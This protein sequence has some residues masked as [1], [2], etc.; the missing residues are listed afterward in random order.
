M[1]MKRYYIYFITV[2]LSFT[3]TSCMEEL[4]YLPG[5]EDAE[6]CYGV[7]FPVQN[8]TGDLQLE[9]GDRTTLTYSV[10]RTNTEGELHVPV[11]I[12]DTAQVFSATEIVFRDE[13]AVAQVQVY[14]PSIELGKTY[15]CTLQIDGDEYVSKYS[16]NSASLRFS[17]TMIKWNNLVGAN[18]ET[19]GKYRDGVFQDW[20]SV[21]SKTA[22]RDILIQERDDMRGYYRMFDVYNAAYMGQI[23]GGSMSGNCVYQSYTYVDATNP[24]KVWIPTFKCGLILHSDYGEVSIGSYVTDNADD[25]GASISSVYGTL[26]EGVISFPSGSLQ[27]KLELMGWYGANNAGTHRIILPGYSAKN[28]EVALTAGVS[29]DNGLL[30]VKVEFGKDVAQV[31]LAAYEGSLTETAAAA[32]AQKI[33]AGT[34]E[35]DVKKIKRETTY[36]FAFE[37]TGMYSVV[38]IALDV[39]GNIQQIANTS[40]GYLNAEDARSDR[41]Q[42][43]VTAGLTVSD[44]YAQEGLTS[45]NSLELYINGKNLQRVHAGIYE[46]DEW[47]KDPEAILSEIRE[48][49][50]SKAYLD[51]VNDKGMSL[52][53]G[54]LVPGTEYVLVV[55]A[56]NG[57]REKV[58][59][60]TRST[61]GKWDARL[62]NYDLSDFSPDLIPANLEGYHGDYRYYA[63]QSG[64]YSRE[65]LGDVNITYGSGSIDGYTYAT[66]S[67]LFPHARK[68]Y[69]MKDD[70]M[71]FVYLD[72]FLYN[73]E[74]VFD[75]FVFEG[76][77]YYPSVLMYTQSGS[78]YGG[79]VGL[80]GGYVADGIFAIVDSGQFA[81]YGEVCDG[82]VVLAYA[83]M[84]HTVYTGFIDLVTEML[85][86]R[87]DVD[88]RLIAE[89]GELVRVEDEEDEDDET[90]TTSQMAHLSHLLVKGPINH[91]ETFEGFMQSTVEQVRGTRYIR[92]YL[93]LDNCK[94][95][96][97]FELKSASFEA[98]AR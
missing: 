30:P 3:M 88:D 85:L 90:V 7:Y 86:V 23:F 76:A 34:A 62:A 17:V 93:D 55:D 44:K 59:V 24:D 6:N 29:D 53:Q 74:Q 11:K 95:S 67:G 18:G 75:H 20:F 82:L 41:K 48:S 28:Y 45:R 40:F 37:Q 61:E 72:G 91:V 63:I 35:A 49:Q 52:R 98:I 84:S 22:E 38:A 26:R 71:T 8:G 94:V 4:K 68:H 25:F 50:L 87:P 1:S 65:Y 92:N 77:Y 54:Y 13:E 19:T 80:M 57:Y 47:D 43:I 83:D 32:E 46:K 96:N 27:M 21:S 10:R 36:D 58:V 97:D 9:P 42:V 64:R 78:A 56:Y 39:S 51:Q 15:E 73:F 2:L 33:L 12:V 69:N 79:M 14:F 5:E 66:V 81:S 70:R 89:N 31:W 16:K 60:A